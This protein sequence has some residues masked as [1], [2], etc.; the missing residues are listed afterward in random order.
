ML[1]DHKFYNF[2]EPEAERDNKLAGFLFL[3]GVI[4]GTVGIV[5]LITYYL[6]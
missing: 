5:K 2:Y 1:D 3:V 4:A 6:A